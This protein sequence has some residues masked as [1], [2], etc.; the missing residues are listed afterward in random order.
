MKNCFQFF[1]VPFLAM[2]L[3]GILAL[4]NLAVNKACGKD[5]SLI[6]HYLM[7]RWPLLIAAYTLVQALPISFF[8]WAQLN[9]TKYHSKG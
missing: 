4:V 2:C 8:F 3:L 6:R 1:F 5:I 9:D 7:P